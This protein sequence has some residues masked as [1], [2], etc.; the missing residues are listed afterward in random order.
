MKIFSF[1]SLNKTVEAQ[2]G[3]F[4]RLCN[5][6]ILGMAFSTFVLSPA[7]LRLNKEKEACVLMVRHKT[8]FHL[9]PTIRGTNGKGT[10]GVDLD[11]T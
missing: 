11:T 9:N 1:H 10:K 5:E 8:S 2:K 3:K 6:F 7:R 4:L